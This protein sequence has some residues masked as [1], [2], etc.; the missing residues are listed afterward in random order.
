MNAYDKIG[1]PDPELAGARPFAGNPKRYRRLA[2]WGSI[3]IHAYLFFGYWAIK[4]FV[5]GEQ[6][7]SSWLVP[8]GVVASAIWF[9]FFSYRW[10]MRLDAQY[11]SGSRWIMESAQIKLPRERSEND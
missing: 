9:A 7:P 3:V 4:T 1:A 2:I 11:G 10:T 6:F 5:A 8:A